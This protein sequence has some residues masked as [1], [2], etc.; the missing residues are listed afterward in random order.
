MP[1]QLEVV[2]LVDRDRCAAVAVE[3]LERTGAAGRAKRGHAGRT[4]PH[5]ELGIHPG[6]AEEVTIEG[7][8]DR[9]AWIRHRWRQPEELWDAALMN[10]I[11]DG[12]RRSVMG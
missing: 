4:D 8:R 11:A 7:T 9:G 5:F 2:G 12:K 10:R 1:E 3:A 6:R